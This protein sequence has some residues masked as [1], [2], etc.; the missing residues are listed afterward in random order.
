MMRTVL[1]AL[2]VVIGVVSLTGH[3]AAQSGMPRPLPAE[4][5]VD[6][7]DPEKARWLASHV[8]AGGPV[9]GGMKFDFPRDFY[10]SRLFLLG[11]SHG[12]AAPQVFDLELLTHL[13]AR[14]G[15]RH[16]L[17]EVDPV[18]AVYLNRYLA[19]GDEALLARVFAYWQ[20]SGAQWANTAFQDKVRGIRSL[21]LRLPAARRIRIVGIDTVQDWALA[22]AWVTDF[23]GSW[24]ADDRCRGRQKACRRTAGAVGKAQRVGRHASACHAGERGRIARS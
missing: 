10:R 18:Q 13:N 14:I 7:A 6:P 1:A 17:A 8:V 21:N 12:Y 2:L 20:A 15:L 4:D 11:E 23:G 16:Y 5:L 24:S 22:A 3:A 9:S 19:S